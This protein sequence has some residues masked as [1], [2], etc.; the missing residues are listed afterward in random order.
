MAWTDEQKKQA[1]D[2]YLKAEPTGDNSSEIIKEIANDME[3]SPNGVRMIL[4]QAQVY[5]KK[6][7]PTTGSAPK[8]GTAAKEGTGT[9]RVS[10][11][12]SIGALVSAI[13]GA[14][15]PVDKEILDKLTGKAAIY[16]TSVIE[17]ILAAAESD[18]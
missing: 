2:A 14:G 18:E 12:S 5:V 6:D 8:A 3:Q 10:K 17:A 9:K 4:V 16:F 7:T 13:E 1:I 15:A 11:E